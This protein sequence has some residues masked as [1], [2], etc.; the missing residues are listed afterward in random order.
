MATEKGRFDRL[1]KSQAFWWV[2]GYFVVLCCGVGLIYYWRVA[3]DFSA[4]GAWTATALVCGGFS[5]LYLL[6]F[7]NAHFI[8]QNYAL[9]C[10]ILVFVAGL[11]FVFANPPLQA[12]DENMHF[13]RA[14]S[15][16]GGNFAFDQQEEFP[17]DVDLLVRDF[18]GNYNWEM[19][20]SDDHSIADA[21][22][23][24]RA[25]LAAND[26]TAPNAE[27]W[28]Q[29]A[30]PHLPAAAGMAVGRIFGASAL[31]CMYL[32][33][34]TNLL[35]YALC[36]YG[37]MRCCKQF[38]SVLTALMLVPI[39]LFMAGSTSSDAVL[40]GLTWLFIGICLSDGV[41]IRRAVALALSFGVLFT[42][43]YNFLA[44]LPLVFLIPK[45]EWTVRGKKLTGKR[46]G[47]ALAAALLLGTLLI[48]GAQT[49]HTALLSNYQGLTYQLGGI[50][51]G[52]QMKFILSNPVR[53]LAVFVY[54]VYLNKGELFS[55]GV[56]GWRD[57][58][59]P[60]VSYFT[61]L[62]LMLSAGFDALCGARA[63]AKTGW[64]LGLTGV[65]FYGFTYTGMYL[66]S[67]PYTMVQILGVQTR[68]L[69]AAF[70][71]G[72]A[73]MAMLCGKTMELQKMTR[74][75]TQKTPPE[76]RMLHISFVFAVISAL[77]LF[78]TYYIGA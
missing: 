14:Y 49:L 44:L 72:F 36:C 32:G 4:L 21:F 45:T 63:K 38:R 74:E 5:V 25:D 6:V 22:E 70:F 48:Y 41:T 73:L 29:Q 16:A 56:F 2:L 78:Q 7:L 18:P 54:S 53:Y 10:A 13:L 33:R 23:R 76:W 8:K 46:W 42:A 1:R 43:K 50:R 66:T 11:G 57:A 24:Y 39:A 35:F 19:P 59:V 64:L 47:W 71:V 60:F 51:P 61:P 31:V 77:L 52:D 65:L 75:T 40:L 69:L 62:L 20:L 17:A 15:L 9:K 28:I 3:Y 27:T 67:T 26:T 30:L 68:Y 34:L 37:G 58:I 55:G 12:P